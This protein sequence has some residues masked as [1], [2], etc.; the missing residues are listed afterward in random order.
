[1]ARDPLAVL[2][3]LREAAVA[4]AGR[5]LAQ[6]RDG[7]R[8]AMLRLDV[9]REQ[10]RCEQA[11]TGPEDVATFAVWL[12]QARLQ[13]QRGQASL[14]EAETHVPRLQQV[15]VGRRT[16]SEAVA[17]A[18]QR[19]HATAALVLARR[20]QAVMDEAAGRRGQ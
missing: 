15:L 4:E 11:D 10:L 19:R 13:L 9:L 8:R 2:W 3:R 5:E 6:A 16:E 7:V 18:M 1:M 20:E 12:P 17:K 14:L